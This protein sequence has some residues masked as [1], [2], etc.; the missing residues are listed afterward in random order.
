MQ[1]IWVIGS[2]ERINELRNQSYFTQIAES[3]FFTDMEAALVRLQ[4]TSG[5][6][7]VLDLNLDERSSEIHK[8]LFSLPET[9]VIGCAVKK[10]LVEMVS[11][12]GTV[13][14]G[15]LIGMNALPGFINR[16]IWEV[17]LLPED[18]APVLAELMGNWGIEYKIVQ[19]RVGMV[20]PR[21][22]AL[23]INEAYFTLEEGAANRQDIDAAMKLGVNY[24]LGPFEWVDKIGLENIA[25]LLIALQQTHTDPKFRLCSTLKNE[26]YHRIKSIK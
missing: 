26:Y 6:S 25:E 20:A 17:S 18:I 21:V 1:N 15:G 3:Y 10:S 8:L 7:V 19:D 11:Y 9:L 23:I 5:I 13:P 22:L 2:R 4:T 12:A 24:P 14:V 16:K